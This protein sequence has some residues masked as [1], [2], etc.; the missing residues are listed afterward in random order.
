MQDL[1]ICK[2]L[3]IRK[4]SPK[5][6]VDRKPDKGITGIEC[7]PLG[8]IVVAILYEDEHTGPFNS[9]SPGQKEKL[10]MNELKPDKTYPDPHI[11]QMSP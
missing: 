1:Q 11:D 7:Q 8:D 6:Q 5:D 2:K 3:W 4:G 9:A 10:K